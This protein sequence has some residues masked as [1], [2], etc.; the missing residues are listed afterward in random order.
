VRHERIDGVTLSQALAA[1][2]AE[3]DR[4]GSFPE[5]A[6]DVLRSLGHVG[7]PPLEGARAVDLFRLLAEVGRGDLSTG[8]IFEG[9]V[10][11]LLL[12]RTHGTLAQRDRCNAIARDGGLFGVWNTDAPDDPLRLE[13]TTLQG[14][15]NFAS[16]VDGLSQAIVTV[17][18]PAGRQMLLVPLAGLP[19]DRSWWT[20][21]G[22]H[23]SGSHIVDFTRTEIQPDWLLGAPDAYIGQ[24]WFSA[25]AMRF[26]SVQVGGMHAVFDEALAHLVKTRRDG[27]PYQKQRL[28]RMG[29]AVETGYAWLGRAGAAWAE[30]AQPD[31]PAGTDEA[32]IALANGFR[33]VV[34]TSAL[35][36]LEEA[37]RAVGAAGFI[38]PHP[39]ERRMR[40]LRTYLR[41]PNPDGA[42]AGLGT[43]IAAGHWAPGQRHDC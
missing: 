25:G 20:P 24:P 38:S 41:Q 10:N 30:A 11:T 28:A 34:E 40:D 4:T 27:D 18:G 39:L 6:F 7:A 33:S 5:P 35:A 21:T 2:G 19:V 43:A 32:L 37:E 29:M 12:V 15:K 42:L 13:G 31:A 26:A 9:H 36:V 3:H 8:R 17:T 23:A 1:T 16:G 22:M 14:K